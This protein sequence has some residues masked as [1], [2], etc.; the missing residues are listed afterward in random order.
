MP[1][2]RAITRLRDADDVSLGTTPNDGDL[3]QYSAAAGKWLNKSGG[4]NPADYVVYASGGTV[5]ANAVTAGLASFSGP[6]SDAAAVIQQA[7]NALYAANGGTIVFKGALTFAS[8]LV[9]KPGVALHGTGLLTAQTPQATGSVITSTYNGTTIL[10]TGDAAGNTFIDLRDFV[11]RGTAGL[12][13]QNLVGL[14]SS[15][16]GVLKDAYLTRVGVF[17]SGQHGVYMNTAGKL[18]L[19]GCYLES[20]AGDG[21]NIAANATVSIAN[22][23]I[24]GQTGN[25][26]RSVSASFLS[27]QNSRI[28][29]NTGYGWLVDS[30]TVFYAV[31]NDIDTNG[32]SSD[33]GC[34]CGATTTIILQIVG[35]RFNDSRG[36]SAVNYLLGVAT[37]HAAF[38]TVAHNSFVGQKNTIPL[39]VRAFSTNTLTVTNN[40]GLND[41]AGKLASPFDNTQNRIGIEG[42]TA[43][44]VASTA[45]KGCTPLYLVV[46]GGTGVSITM[47]DPAGNAVQSGLSSFTGPLPVGYSINF[48]A[49]SAPPT[50]YVGVA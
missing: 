2:I 46:S 39:Y 9:L 28:W 18:W 48:G 19:D 24:F 13:S 1:S 30:A 21:M 22:S 26:V 40:D 27:I 47:T 12:T 23:Y 33:Y 34:K 31:G 38:G 42:G 8:Q 29:S 7:A 25:G 15:G 6:A 41:K 5:Y 49:F 4:S 20:N 16:G 37:N 43:A 11:I 50:V 36:A 3:L 44:P 35:N 32:P 10:L 45:Y 17:S 14:D